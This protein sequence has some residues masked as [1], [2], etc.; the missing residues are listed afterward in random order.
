MKISYFITGLGLGGA[1][2]V[3][4]GIANKMIERGHQVQLV[5]LTGA[6]EHLSTL[7]QAIEVVGLGMRKNPIGFIYALIKASKLI[8]IFQPDVVHANMIHANLFAR[9]LRFFQNIPYLICSEHSKNIEGH[10]RMKL[11]QCSNF[12]SDI[13]TNVSQEAVTH[14]IAQRAFNAQNS[15]CI[16][17]GI[18]LQKF[19]YDEAKRIKIRTQYNIA[20]SEFVYINVGRLTEAKDQVNL[21]NAFAKVPLGKLMI[22]GKGEKEQELKTL[23]EQL[24]LSHRVILTGVQPNVEAY[25]SAADCFVLSSAWEGFGIVLAEAMS[26]SLPVISTDCGGCAEVVSNPNYVVPTK[27]AE[28]LA[29]KMRYVANMPLV[30]RQ[31]QGIKNK[32][33]AQ[34]F[35]IHK[36]CDRWEEVYQ[37]KAKGK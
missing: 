31:K 12:L 4:I 17:N 35:D 28:V 32:E 33:L 5:Y 1:E 22:V 2:I 13:N 36:I 23:I 6:N 27:N 8:K 18:D 21:L 37:S 29:E 30:E 34:R 16:Y 20:Q 3:T 25:L 19:Q 15:F 7:H 24:K 26:C 9:V 10:L 11:Y 14:F